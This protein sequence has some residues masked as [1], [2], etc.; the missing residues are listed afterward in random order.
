[1]GCPTWIRE[2][3]LLVATG[4]E[5]KLLKPSENLVLFLC[6]KT[7]TVVACVWVGDENDEVQ[8][9]FNKKKSRRPEQLFPWTILPLQFLDLLEENPN[10]RALPFAI[11]LKE[12]YP[13]FWDIDTVTLS[14]PTV[15]L[16]PNT[17]ILF[18]F[19]S[20]LYSNLC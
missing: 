9:D 18:I 14:S 7:F 10:H 4:K 16:K 15:Y 5:Y 3:R 6:Y 19:V 8:M 1:M 2:L 13:P 11:G 17:F 20:G 12:H